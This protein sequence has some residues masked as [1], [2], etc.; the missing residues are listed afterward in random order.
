VA[1]WQ[2]HA[3]FAFF[4]S[5]PVVNF[6]AAAAARL[7]QLRCSGVHLGAMDL[8]IAAIGLAPEAVLLSRNLADFRRVSGLRVEDWAESE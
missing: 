8:K 5:I 6:D 7:V 3:L 2:L 4:E 1:Y